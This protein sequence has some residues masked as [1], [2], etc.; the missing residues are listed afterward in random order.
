[1]FLPSVLKR[2]QT[3][4]WLLLAV[5]VALYMLGAFFQ[6]YAE[7]MLILASSLLLRIWIHYKNEK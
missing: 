3:R 4:Y 7:G 6:H 5:M 1:V 2:R